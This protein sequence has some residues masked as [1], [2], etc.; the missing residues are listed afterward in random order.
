M[1]GSPLTYE[2][3]EPHLHREF[4]F[5]GRPQVL[6]L[7]EIDVKDRP[8]APGRPDKAFALIFSGPRG[9]VLPEGL[10]NAEAE[11]G[12]RFEFYIMPIHTPPTDRQDYQVVF[13]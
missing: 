10:Y 7:S 13:N 11:G 12:A 9:D 1:A 5:E 8:R 6:R 3:F 4:R 2:D